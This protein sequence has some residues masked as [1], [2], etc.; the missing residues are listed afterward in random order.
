MRLVS[1]SIGSDPSNLG[2]VCAAI[3][4]FKAN[5]KGFQRNRGWQSIV[6]ESN[7]RILHYGDSEPC[8]HNPA[9]DNVSSEHLPIFSIL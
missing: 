9:V 4:R 5:Q 6:N 7:K 2:V 8:V 3:C 1:R